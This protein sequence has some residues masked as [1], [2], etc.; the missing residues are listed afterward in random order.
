[1]TKIMLNGVYD[2]SMAQYRG[3][4]ADGMSMSASDAIILANATPAHLKAAWEEPEERELRANMGTA[5]HV[6]AL[7]PL[8]ASSAIAV[9]ASDSFRT[10]VAKEEAEAALAAGKVPLLTEMYDR[11]CAAAR[12][13]WAS[14]D[15]G[16]LL[17]GGTPEQSYFAR[18]G[19][20]WRKCRPDL[21]NGA[22]AIID[23]KSV[24]SA[25]QDF[26]RRRIYDGGWYMQ[27]PFH[28]DVVE[29]VL[30]APP[31]DYLWIC[32]EQDP[33]HAVKVYRPTVGTLAEGQRK[34]FRAISTFINCVHTGRW[35]AYAPGIDEI[36]LPDFAHY[37]LEE[38]A[39][40][41]DAPPAAGFE[42]ARL[43]RELNA[44]PFG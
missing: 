21:V 39:L 27:A 8:R 4:P 24:G 10:K 3:Q 29:R 7:E 43:G 22:G 16:P 1:M 37:K 17:A 44:S 40:E 26:I 20:I 12:A 35:P 28:C 18:T 6:L 2:L 38:E 25:H 14:E 5:I 11:A 15:A 42:A 34:N 41:R 9:I 31:S 36:S 32:V 19:S 13:I 30:G 23:I 33:P